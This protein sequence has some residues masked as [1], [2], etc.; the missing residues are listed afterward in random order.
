MKNYSCLH[1]NFVTNFEPTQCSKCGRFLFLPTLKPSSNVSVIEAANDYKDYE[2][3]Y[4]NSFNGFIAG[5]NWQKEQDKA[6]I[7]ELLSLLK[8]AK[9]YSCP[10][11]D[12][13]G[14]IDYANFENDFHLSISK[15]E[16][17]INQ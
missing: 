6:I 7:E 3:I 17:Y 11:S 4:E 9:T 5:A 14:R 8:L 15:A 13:V 10:E 2:A 1:C 12:F 16:Q